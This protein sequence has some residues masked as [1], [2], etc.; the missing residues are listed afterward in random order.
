MSWFNPSPKKHPQKMVV[1]Q[2]HFVGEQDGP[3]ERELKERLVAFFHR[4]QS[5]Q[6][7]YLARA[8]YGEQGAVN[9][10]LCLRTQFGPDGGLAEKVGRIFATMFGSH[11]HL[12]M[13]FLTPAQETALAKVCTPFFNRNSGQSKAD[14][15]SDDKDAQS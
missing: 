6:T 15:E 12:D 3:P 4:D 7:A 13:V 2:P 10:A 14:T 11:E 8:M 9:V 1:A 5:V